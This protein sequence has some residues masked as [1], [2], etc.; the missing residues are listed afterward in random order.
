M[1]VWAWRM[2]APGQSAAGQG[3]VLP[4]PSGACRGEPCHAAPCL[5]PPCRALQ[6]RRL[7]AST[8]GAFALPRSYAAIFKHAKD[9]PGPASIPS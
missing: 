6:P 5:A 3:P 4:P 8:A 7:Q 9:E 1:A 2:L